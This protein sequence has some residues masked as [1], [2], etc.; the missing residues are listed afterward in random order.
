MRRTCR[1]AH[2]GLSACRAATCHGKRRP[3]WNPSRAC[4]TPPR[5]HPA[6]CTCRPEA[7][8]CHPP[9]T[10]PTNQTLLCAHHRPC[11]I[12]AKS[13]FCICVPAKFTFCIRV[14]S[15]PTFC[16]CV[17]RG[18]MPHFLPPFQPI[19][20]LPPF[21]LQQGVGH[22]EPALHSGKTHFLYLCSSKSPFLCLCS[23]HP[24]PASSPSMN[25]EG[26]KPSLLCVLLQP[27]MTYV[28]REK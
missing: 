8:R 1:V 21:Q 19:Q 9:A 6:T 10:K 28:N 2:Q 11:C 25:E 20:F 4:P 22:C 3:D 15:E 17:P 7:T 12:P 27:T 24:M 5:T 26:V 14:F 23:S 18:E 16:V 13:T